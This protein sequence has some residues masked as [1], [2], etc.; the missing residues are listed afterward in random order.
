MGVGPRDPLPTCERCQHFVVRASDLSVCEP[1][2]RGWQLQVSLRSVVAADRDETAVVFLQE[3][4][5]LLEEW[6]VKL[7]ELEANEGDSNP[8]AS[9]A[10]ER[11]P[12][13]RKEDRREKEAQSSSPKESKPVGEENTRSE[14]P[15]RAVAPPPKAIASP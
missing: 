8:R 2:R 13:K 11:S 9:S 5:T 1:C 3:C 15:Q 14:K 10:R 12:L 6:I 4:H 7:R